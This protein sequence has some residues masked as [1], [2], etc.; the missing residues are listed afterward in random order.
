MNGFFSLY[1]SLGIRNFNM[2]D[3]W[4]GFERDHL[5]KRQYSSK[6]ELFFYL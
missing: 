2:H 3:D 6:Y 1:A 4:L 5:T